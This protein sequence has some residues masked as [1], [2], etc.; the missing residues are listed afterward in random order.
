MKDVSVGEDQ[1][2]Q[3]L[4]PALSFLHGLSSSADRRTEPEPPIFIFPRHVVVDLTYTTVSRG[5]L[6][7]PQSGLA[8]QIY[9]NSVWL[10]ELPGRQN[11]SV[12]VATAMLL[13]GAPERRKRRFAS[14][15]RRQ[16]EGAILPNIHAR[17]FVHVCYPRVLRCSSPLVRHAAVTQLSPGLS[18][19]L[20]GGASLPLAFSGR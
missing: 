2:T 6:L 4:L 13:L 8:V 18:T 12:V 15:F 14:F 19:R 5:A 20:H 10:A 7:A 11:N 3:P 17:G 9:V 1:T 16:G